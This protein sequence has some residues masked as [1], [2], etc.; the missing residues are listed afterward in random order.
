MDSQK[1]NNQTEKGCDVMDSPKN[2]ALKAHNQNIAEKPLIDKMEKEFL[3]F[4]QQIEKIA[5]AVKDE[6]ISNEE[7]Q[8][9]YEIIDEKVAR[10]QAEHKAEIDAL[11]KWIKEN[12]A[13]LKSNHERMDIIESAIDTIMETEDETK[14]LLN[15]AKLIF[16]QLEENKEKNHS[17]HLALT[18]T[19]TNLRKYIVGSLES[20]QEDNGK[21]FMYTYILFGLTIVAVV[22]DI[23]IRLVRG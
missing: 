5:Q 6:T 23:I 17:E 9:A 14:A 2:A 4:N 1:N 15:N 18:E 10:L 16:N 22:A 7:A 19:I 21:N 13:V 8:K 3:N 11:N 20:Q 12:E